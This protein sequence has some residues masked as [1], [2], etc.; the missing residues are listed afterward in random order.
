MKSHNDYQYEE[1]LHAADYMYYQTFVLIRL[2]VSAQISDSVR[3]AVLGLGFEVVNIGTVSIC[4]L[5]RQYFLA[6]CYAAYNHSRENRLYECCRATNSR[7]LNYVS[8]SDVL[9][10]HVC[11]GTAVFSLVYT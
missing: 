11:T 9:S 8:A 4:S 6:C 1:I 3:S 7:T 5:P 10:N 2:V